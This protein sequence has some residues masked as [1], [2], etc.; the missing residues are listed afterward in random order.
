ML[1]SDN[2]DTRLSYP[3]WVQDEFNQV[4][5]FSRGLISPDGEPAGWVIDADVQQGWTR[6][7]PATPDGA[8]WAVLAL[9][10]ADRINAD[11][12]AIANV[13]TILTRY[14]GLAS[15][16]IKPSKSSDGYI[17][18]WIDP[19]T[20]NTKP[21]G[22]S[23]EFAVYSQM[24]IDVA[25]DRAAAYFPNDTAIRK[26]RNAIIGQV[27][28]WDGY[29][30]N[31]PYNV[32]LISKAN[33]GPDHSVQNGAF[34]E[35][36]LFVEQAAAYGGSHAS[37]GFNYWINP[38]GKPT[39]SYITGR[40]VI[41]SGNGSFNAAFIDIYPQLVQRPYR[42]SAG[43]QQSVRNSL[44][45]HSGWT[46]DNGPRYFTVF[47]AGT[48]ESQWGG[49]NAD[50]LSNHPGNVTTFPALMGYCALGGSTTS[51]AVSAYEAYRHGARQTFLNGAS[52]L[53]RR[54]DVD[55]PY[56]PDS[57]AL[58]DVVMGGLGLAELLQPGSIDAVLSRT[59]TPLTCPTDF[60]LDNVTNTVDLGILLSHFGQSV[61]AGTLGDAN[62]DGHVDTLDLGL[63]L[64]AFGTTCP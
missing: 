37:D 26:A 50:S 31:S 49:Y 53:Y 5:A 3:A 57:A 21:G 28:N 41:T 64:G 11:P 60:S 36:I 51:P 56:Q 63:L 58:A 40:P 35:G 46:D 32:D 10:M 29:I 62:I 39:A 25:A 23:A 52:I 48:T 54:S 7:H 20:G 33:G 38:S 24:L 22:W 42:Q 45:S 55:R 59:Y 4:V 30:E 47:S 34:T 61:P 6:F 43:W 19:L 2:T 1:I 9:L 13:R 16:N 8:N 14:A 44:E 18:H 15:D 12:N 27:N 17:R